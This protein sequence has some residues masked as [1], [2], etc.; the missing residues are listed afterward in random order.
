MKIGVPKETAAGE[1]RV[2]LTP[3]MVGRLVGAG[4]EVVVESG[5][6]EESLYTDEAYTGAGAIPC[7][8]TPLPFWA[9]STL[10][11]EVQSAPA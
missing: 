9:A 2:A 7:A 11:S 4:L 3:D 6:G 10:S 5:A 1:R 8:R